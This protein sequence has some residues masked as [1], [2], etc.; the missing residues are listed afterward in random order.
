M[1]Y[2]KLQFD[3]CCVCPL[4]TKILDEIL[5]INKLIIEVM[6]MYVADLYICHQ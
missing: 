4:L 1:E 6:Y 3:N 5:I 2:Q